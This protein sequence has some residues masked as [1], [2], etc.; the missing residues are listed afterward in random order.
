MED[1]ILRMTHFKLTFPTRFTFYGLQQEEIDNV[2][3]NSYD[4]NHR[5]INAKKFSSLIIF[6]LEMSLLCLWEDAS[7]SDL[8]EAAYFLA[9]KVLKVSS[10]IISD[11]VMELA[12]KLMGVWRENERGI[13]AFLYDNEKYCFVGG[14]KI[15]Y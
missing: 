4:S 8:A 2:I 13:L 11:S 1:K 6:L 10:P 14:L 3:A 12:Y 15:I 7:E 5:T 9:C